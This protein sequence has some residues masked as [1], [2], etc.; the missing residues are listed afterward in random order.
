VQ[1]L[2][3]FVNGSRPTAREKN[4]KVFI[5]SS[6]VMDICGD[7]LVYAIAAAQKLR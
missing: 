4:V 6:G 2:L 3:L 5:A 7:K 1:A